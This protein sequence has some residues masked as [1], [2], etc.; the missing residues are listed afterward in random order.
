MYFGLKYEFGAPVEIV[1]KR[2]GFW[3]LEM[4]KTLKMGEFVHLWSSIQQSLRK[5]KSLSFSG[6]RKMFY[7]ISWHISTECQIHKKIG[8]RKKNSIIYFP[9][10]QFFHSA[11][12]FVL[13]ELQ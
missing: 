2:R 8:F 10:P 4:I 11:Y 6:Q 7:S 1:A 9:R 13:D 5:D 3:L 12:V